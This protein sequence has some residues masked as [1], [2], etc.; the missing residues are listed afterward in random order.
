MAAKVSIAA[1]T[2]FYSKE[3]WSKELVENYKK[4]LA[5]VRGG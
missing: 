3:D 4:K 2:D 5:E 1:R